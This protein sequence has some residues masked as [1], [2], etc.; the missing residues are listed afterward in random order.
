[1]QFNSERV[2]YYYKLAVWM[3]DNSSFT[4]LK[5]NLRKAKELIKKPGNIKNGSISEE[6]QEENVIAAI[7]SQGN[8][9]GFFSKLENR[10]NRL[11]GEVTTLS[12]KVEAGCE[13][14]LNK[15]ERW[16]ICKIP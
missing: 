12:S 5:Q 8:Q 16:K 3:L 9:N 15:V 11:E 4:K 1:M 6:R 2:N 10:V 13:M 7:Q 14:S